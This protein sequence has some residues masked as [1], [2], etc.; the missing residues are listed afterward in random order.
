MPCYFLKPKI[1]EALDE[2]TDVTQREI[3]IELLKEYTNEELH[4]MSE[5]LLYILILAVY[6]K[7][8]KKKMR[9]EVKLIY[10]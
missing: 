6:E 4:E 7:L 2:L 1:K 3:E 5:D 9:K 10:I 8:K